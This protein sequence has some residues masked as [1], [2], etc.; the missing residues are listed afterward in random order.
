[1]Q[2]SE[3]VALTFMR[4]HAEDAARVV[5]TLP[6]PEAGRLLS[7]IPVQVAAG[8]AQRMGLGPAQLI[9]KEMEADPAAKVLAAMETEHAALLA[10]R[11]PEDK[12]RPVLQAMEEG[13]RE[14]LNRLLN[15]PVGTAGALM[16]VETPAL[17]QEML[18]GQAWEQVR[19]SLQ[20]TVHYV[21][22]VQRSRVLVGAISLNELIAAPKERQLRT[23]MASDPVSLS[24]ELTGPAL[25]T[26]PGW[27]KHSALP[28]VDLQGR[29][30][31]VIQHE[32]V[33]RLEANYRARQ[34]SNVSDVGL[35]LGE[36]YWVGLSKFTEGIAR[37]LF[38]EP[39][40]KH[41]EDR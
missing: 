25:V 28:V 19:T 2:P 41:Q 31:G 18:V 40:T 26:H 35:E 22:V 32:T 38:G 37:S 24:P 12:R 6:P 23:V 21:Y 16:D 30:L 8:V 20:R 36:L 9:L 33:R 34:G 10:R 5:E 39:E 4:N 14:K 29:F 27:M 15:Y 1:M 7:G 17:P 3:L 13:R 11:L